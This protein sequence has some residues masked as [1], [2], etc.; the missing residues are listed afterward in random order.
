M[1]KIT[2]ICGQLEA[3]RRAGEKLAKPPTHKRC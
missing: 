2:H 3:R 1:K